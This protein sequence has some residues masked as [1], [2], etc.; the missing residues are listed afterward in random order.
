MGP[1]GYSVQIIPIASGK[2]GVGKSLVAANLG[3]ALAQAGRRV[4]L[5]DL[6][7]GGSNL[8]LIL[9]LRGIPFGIGTW[10]NS[11]ELDFED[12]VMDTDVDNLRF[13]PGDSE[14][15]GMANLKPQQKRN[16][17]RGLMALTDTDILI[18]DLGAGTSL[19]T[20]DFFLMSGRGV[21]ITT[22]TL[23]AT[24]NAYFFLKNA[25]FRILDTSFAKGSWA[26]LQY[27]KLI[28]GGS[29][30]QKLYI[31]KFLDRMKEKDPVSWAAYQKS[32]AHF[33]P[34]LIFNMLEDPNDVEKANKVRRSCREYLG[35]DLEHLGVIYRDELQDIALSA[36][37]PIVLYKPQSVLSMA[38][39]RIADKILS[40]EAD[41]SGPL[42]FQAL[43]ETHQTALLEA[44]V[45]FEAKMTYLQ[46]LLQTG[47]LSLGD[48][49]E[50]VKTQQF[51]INQLK[52]ENL[53]LKS[54]IVK[55][56]QGGF[57]P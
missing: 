1:G 56:I 35:F 20:I 50:M 4:V 38:I 44:E 29:A 27:H 18:L 54:K 6:D 47:A 3:I 37:L 43:E 5:A 34:R 13:I 28:A 14:I 2:G 31:P 45:D 23:T 53:L 42:D 32:A 22:P 24:L 52:K 9:G 19:N 7:L 57:R 36:R 25:V 10:F 15:P 55:A 17:I 39:Y 21:I 48:L 40:F 49:M 41:E 33:Q 46:E 8:H 11:P 30:L 12:L 16:L 26:E 51:E